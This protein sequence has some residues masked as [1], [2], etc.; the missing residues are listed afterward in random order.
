MRNGRDVI[1]VGAGT[2]GSSAA[3]HLAKSGVNVTLV[4][5]THPAGGLSGKSSAL[6]HAFYLMP[7]LSQLSNRG[8]LRAAVRA[9]AAGE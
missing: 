1:V 2:V 5:Q 4:E 7:E 9:N 3:Y 8:L 6:L